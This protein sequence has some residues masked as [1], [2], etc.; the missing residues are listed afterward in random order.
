MVLASIAREPRPLMPERSFNAPPMA[1][2]VA[3]HAGYRGE[4]TPR[5]FR[6]GEGEVLVNE[7]LDRWLAPDHRYFKVAGSDGNT[8]ILRHDITSGHW[9]ATMFRRGSARADTARPGRA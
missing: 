6:L 1:I 4:E 5:R 8:W 2:E 7:V 9:E 3:C